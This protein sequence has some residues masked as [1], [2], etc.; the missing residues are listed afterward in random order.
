[1]SCPACASVR[2][3]GTPKP[4]PTRQKAVSPKSLHSFSLQRRSIMFDKVSQAAEKLATNVSRRAF[5][6]RLGKGTLGAA[7]VLAG[8]LAFPKVAQAG[9]Y[10]G[11]PCPAWDCN[12]A[13]I[14]AFSRPFPD[15]KKV[16]YPCCCGR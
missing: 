10:S 6:G 8:V 4:T 16:H 14:C 3:T 9:C 5:L 12:G 7:G 2:T 13:L 15:C 1:M 11:S